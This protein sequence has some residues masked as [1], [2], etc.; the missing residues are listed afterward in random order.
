MWRRSSGPLRSSRFSRFLGHITATA[1]R[2]APLCLAL[3]ERQLTRGR[4]EGG[5]PN[6]DELRARRMRSVESRRSRDEWS[7]SGLGDVRLMWRLDRPTVLNC[8]EKRAER[9]ITGLATEELGAGTGRVLRWAAD[10]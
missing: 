2:F 5:C 4:F 10:T 1:Q 8:R 6:H 7:F 9:H 3:D